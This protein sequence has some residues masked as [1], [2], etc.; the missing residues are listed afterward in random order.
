LA[1][2]QFAGLALGATDALCKIFLGGHSRT[3]AVQFSDAMGSNAVSSAPVF[4]QVMIG[5][6]TILGTV[7]IWLELMVRSAAVYVATFFM[8]LAL[9]GYV[10]PATTRMARRVVEIL[11]ALILSKFVIVASLS[12]GL[13]ALS[14]DTGVDAAVSGA[15]I[16]LL[17]GFAPF[18]LLKLVPVV[19]ASA[20][21]HL[22]G[23][24]R[25]PFQAAT[26]AVTFAAGAR[27]HPV[28][29]LL[30]SRSSGSNGGNTVTADPVLPQPVPEH[31]AD[32]PL[33][34]SRSSDH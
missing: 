28:T 4:V 27:T 8:P 9:A 3:I 33:A 6:V 25:R 26:Q 18:T 2:S 23:M 31:R 21:A 15:G 5:G 7:M 1:G 11:A 12:L 17:A 14:S 24:S 22:E 20:I 29:Q 13:A 30:M 19:E 32:W 10:W 16:L 34:G